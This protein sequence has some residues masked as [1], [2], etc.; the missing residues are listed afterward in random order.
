MSDGWEVSN[1]LNP[2]IDE[3][4]DDSDG[5]N[6]SNLN[7]Y[8]NNTDSNNSDTDDDGLSDGVV[9]IIILIFNNN[10]CLIFMFEQF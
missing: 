7:E 6:L 10:I 4:H 2:L 8:T 9:F 1:S 3:S 5:D